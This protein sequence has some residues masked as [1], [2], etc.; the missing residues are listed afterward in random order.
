MALSQSSGVG[1]AV[2]ALA[3]ATGCENDRTIIV[4]ADAGNGRIVQMDDFSGAGWTTFAY[5]RVNNSLIAPTAVAVDSLGRI[6][7][8]NTADNN[9][10]R[11]DDIFG[12]GFVTL[13]RGG[14]GVGE[15]NGPFGIAIDAE[16]RIYVADAE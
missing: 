1:V 7:A 4:V 5:P 12:L 10:S 2:L 8:V 6:Y 15:F 13:G 16:D 14:S 9:I 11:M 3:L